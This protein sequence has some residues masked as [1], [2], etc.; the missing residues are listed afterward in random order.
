VPDEVIIKVIKGVL[1]VES[2]NSS[3]EYFVT[4]KYYYICVHSLNSVQVNGGHV[5]QKVCIFSAVYRY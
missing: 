5:C 2:H 3:V 1:P 4:V